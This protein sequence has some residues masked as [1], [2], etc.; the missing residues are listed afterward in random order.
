MQVK[1]LE[2]RLKEVRELS[3]QLKAARD[4]MCQAGEL[5]A[6]VIELHLRK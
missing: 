5:H 4:Q 2:A 1:L 6:E 3:T